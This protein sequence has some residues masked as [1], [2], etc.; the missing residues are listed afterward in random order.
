[1]KSNP[2]RISLCDSEFYWWLR[3]RFLPS[4]VKVPIWGPVDNRS[5]DLELKE[6]V[7]M[8]EGVTVNKSTT[9]EGSLNVGHS[10]SMSAGFDIPL[11]GE[12]SVETSLSFN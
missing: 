1:M 10:L 5:S 9:F 8:T 2:S 3:Q 11:V 6:S 7:T 4:Y 12:G